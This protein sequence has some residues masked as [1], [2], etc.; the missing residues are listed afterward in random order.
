MLIKVGSRF[1]ETFEQHVIQ[2]KP[3]WL[4]VL[5]KDGEGG[6]DDHTESVSGSRASFSFD[7]LNPIAKHN[8]VILVSC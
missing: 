1:L 3:Y 4:E 5:S 7:H 2:T 6:G 8:I